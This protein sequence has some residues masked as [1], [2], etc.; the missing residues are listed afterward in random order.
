MKDLTGTWRGMFSYPGELA[1][2][3]FTA[4]LRENGGSLT[5]LT[6]EMDD[7]GDG[8]GPELFTAVVQ[9][10]RSGSQ[11]ELRKTYDDFDPICVVDY[12]G[13]IDAEASEIRGDW[14]RLDDLLSGPFV[15]RREHA[16]DEESAKLAEATSAL[17]R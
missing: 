6:H 3:Q 8:R 10:V 4:E 17:D 2:V 16:A 11:V 15:M 12:F 14:I 5:G 1:A 13:T 7:M 9:G